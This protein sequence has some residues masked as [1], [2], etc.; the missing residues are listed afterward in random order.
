MNPLASAAIA[1]VFR[2]ALNFLAG[3][4]LTVG[5]WTADD[6]TKYVEAGALVLVSITWSMIH[7]YGVDKKFKELTG[8]GDGQ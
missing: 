3:Y 2:A 1:S 6:T 8:Y 4:A 5:I 7:K